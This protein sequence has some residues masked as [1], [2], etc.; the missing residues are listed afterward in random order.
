M[1]F[2]SRLVLS[3]LHGNKSMKIQTRQ[4]ECLEDE[5]RCESDGEC[6]DGD[7]VC[8]AINDCN[9]ASDEEHCANCTHES[10]YRCNDGSCIYKAFRCDDTIQCVGGE[11]EQD[12]AGCALDEF[13]CPSNNSCIDGDFVCDGENDCGDFSDEE[14]CAD[15]THESLY[16]CYDGQCMYKGFQCN[17]INDCVGGDDED[18]YNCLVPNELVCEGD[19]MLLAVTQDWL[20]HILNIGDAEAGDFH[21]NFINCTGHMIDDL[22]VFETMLGDC[23]TT[24]MVE[25]GKAINYTNTVYNDRGT[26]VIEMTCV[27]PMEYE[28]E[29]IYFIANPCALL[30]HFLGIGTFSAVTSLYTNDTFTALLNP[31]TDY[32]VEICNGTLIYFGIAIDTNDGD[33]ELFVKNCFMSESVN[34]GLSPTYDFITDGCLTDR[35]NE[36]DVLPVYVFEKKH[37]GVDV[38]DV[39]HG[40][41]VGVG[42][43]IELYLHCSIVTCLIYQDETPCDLVCM[44]NS[45]NYYS[46]FFQKMIKF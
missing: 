27:Y 31:A 14:Y 32:P 16:Q 38:Y 29:P 46:Y 18:M 25:D 37:Y 3:P 10:V 21:F 20:I 33:L 30:A 44:D 12:C 28:L 1:V 19:K 40:V 22:F 17:G 13:T 26:G 8:D 42:D 6:I 45:S 34:P 24:S 5:F 41:D 7:G 11:D 4:F 9:D 39:V 23:G 15:C 2:Y 36:Y 35:V 43:N